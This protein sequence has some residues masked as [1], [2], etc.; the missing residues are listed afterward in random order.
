MTIYGL[1]PYAS[2]LI[3]WSIVLVGSVILLRRGYAAA[4][5]PM[6]LGVAIVLAMGLL[7]LLM[8]TLVMLG[9]AQQGTAR[10][11]IMMITWL[12]SIVGIFLFS[13]GFLHL[14]LTTKREG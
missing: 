4:A 2:S 6:L 14:A 11:R 9:S 3:V 13:L 12:G 5:V 10:G 8:M 1:L 7:N